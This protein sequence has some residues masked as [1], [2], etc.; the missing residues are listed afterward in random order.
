MQCIESDFNDIIQN[1]QTFLLE[2]HR[3][4]IACWQV[5]SIVVNNVIRQIETFDWSTLSLNKSKRWTGLTNH[6]ANSDSSSIMDPQ[7]FVPLPSVD[8]YIKD[9]FA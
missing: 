6:R 4:P 8:C 3:R 5:H 2:I 1:I 9:C 7:V